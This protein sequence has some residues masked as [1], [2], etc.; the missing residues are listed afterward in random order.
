MEIGNLIKNVLCKK[1]VLELNKLKQENVELRNKLAL[2]Q[3]QINKVNH[4]WK[5]VLASKTRSK[6][7]VR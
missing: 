3:E 5:K 1:L 4:Y 6:P 7:V 2:K